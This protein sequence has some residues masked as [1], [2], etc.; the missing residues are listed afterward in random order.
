MNTRR[1]RNQI[2]CTGFFIACR[3][4]VCFIFVF[5]AYSN[6]VYAAGAWVTGTVGP[7]F[8]GNDSINPGDRGV[9]LNTGLPLACANN[10][11]GFSKS[12]THLMA[13]LLAAKL[14]GKTVTIFY[15]DSAVSTHI[16]WVNFTS[17][18]IGQMYIN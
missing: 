7:I 2:A 9:Q 13:M 8:G 12:E 10:T 5:A 17:C 3:L 1:F 16:P 15:D 11:I 4:I 18:R 14:S 6:G